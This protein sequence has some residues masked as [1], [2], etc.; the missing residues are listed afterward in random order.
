MEEVPR[1]GGRSKGRE[2]KNLSE[3][4]DMSLIYK[5][6]Q[7]QISC[8]LGQSQFEDHTWDVMLGIPF[9]LTLNT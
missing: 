3:V 8:K 4:G 7:R 2:E 6:N 9:L 1:T 5:V